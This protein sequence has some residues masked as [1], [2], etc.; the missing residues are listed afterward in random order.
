MQINTFISTND[1][2]L[3][4]KITPQITPLHFCSDWLSAVNSVNHFIDESSN[5]KSKNIL[6]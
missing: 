6:I 3:D 1:H 5:H 2:H 4:Y